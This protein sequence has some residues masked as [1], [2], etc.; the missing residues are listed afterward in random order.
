MSS[1]EPQ[2]VDE[3]RADPEYNQITHKHYHRSG[4][5]VLL[6]RRPDPFSPLLTACVQAFALPDDFA[7]LRPVCRAG[8]LVCSRIRLAEM[9]SGVVRPS[10]NRL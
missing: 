10:E 6:S 2:L 5:L 4:T 8:A 3:I 1:V 9:R 7:T